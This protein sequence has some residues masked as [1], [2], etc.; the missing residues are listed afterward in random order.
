VTKPRKAKATCTSSCK[1][2][3][4]NYAP[5]QKKKIRDFFVVFFILRVFTFFLAEDPLGRGIRGS[6]GRWDNQGGT[7]ETQ[8]IFNPLSYIFKVRKGE[9]GKGG[10]GGGRGGDAGGGGGGGGERREEGGGRRRE[11]G[12]G[13]RREREGE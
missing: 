2:K 10:G 11:E 12:G 13:G 1:K 7:G 6:G 4:K 8:D 5:V 9:E 3:N